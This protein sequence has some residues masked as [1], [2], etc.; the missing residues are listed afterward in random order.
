MSKEKISVQTVFLYDKSNLAQKLFITQLDKFISIYGFLNYFDEKKKIHIS[1]ISPTNTVK[2]EIG[3]DSFKNILNCQTTK[4]SEQKAEIVDKKMH[5]ISISNIIK[6]RKREMEVVD[7]II[8]IGQHD[9]G[10][11]NQLNPIEVKIEDDQVLNILNKYQRATYR[12]VPIGLLFTSGINN[13]TEQIFI[14]VKKW[15]QQRKN[16]LSKWE[17]IQLI[18]C[19]KFRTDKK[20]EMYERYI[21]WLRVTFDELQNTKTSRSF[22]FQF[23]HKK[24]KQCIKFSILSFGFKKRTN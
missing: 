12:F 1:I 13:V 17:T 24:H 5:E 20:L 16:L 8:V 10:K 19:C 2:F 22:C 14:T 15:P 6:K 4:V 18:G 9:F 21:I 11:Y 23:H 7:S 3:K